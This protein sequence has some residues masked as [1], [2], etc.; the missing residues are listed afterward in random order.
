MKEYTTEEL[1]VLLMDPTDPDHKKSDKFSA[2]G[3]VAQMGSQHHNE[4]K[5]GYG[6]GMA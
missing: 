5:K 2:E 1:K 6:P 4:D 3:R